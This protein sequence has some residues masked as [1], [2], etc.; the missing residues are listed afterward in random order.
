MRKYRKQI[1]KVDVRISQLSRGNANKTLM[2]EERLA[3]LMGIVKYLS[4]KV[5]RNDK[6]L[7]FISM[8]QHQHNRP[9]NIDFGGTYSNFS[10][11]NYLGP[12][13]FL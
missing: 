1:K 13:K 12:L 8:S 10:L 9:Y 5:E 2:V 7:Q 6:G 11:M 4:Y 3:R